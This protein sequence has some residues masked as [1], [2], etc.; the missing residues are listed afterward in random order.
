MTTSPP[1]KGPAHGRCWRLQSEFAAKSIAFGNEPGDLRHPARLLTTIHHPLSTIHIFL[2][3]ELPRTI[4]GQPRNPRDR[5]N[6]VSIKG[7]RL[8]QCIGERAEV[9]GIEPSSHRGL[10]RCDP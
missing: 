1:G 10:H 2:W 3:S 7:G 4:G 8:A 6:L 5:P 9:V